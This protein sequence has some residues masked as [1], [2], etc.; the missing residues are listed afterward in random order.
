MTQRQRLKRSFLYFEYILLRLIFSIVRSLPLS[1]NYG[2]ARVFG[3]FFY[4]IDAKHRR[5]ARRNLQLAFG[6]TKAEKEYR[7][8]LKA[9]FQHFFTIVVESIFLPKY[10]TSDRWRERVEFSQAPQ[11]KEHLK[12]G[13]GLIILAPHLGNWEAA[14]F[15]V[16]L[17]GI[18]FQVI[19]R[20]LKNPYL[21]QYLRK[22]REMAG[23]EVLP[24]RGGFRG[25]VEA[26]SSGRAVAILHDQN[27]RKRPIFVNFF[28]K[29]AATDRSPA[30]LAL[31]FDTPVVVAAL[32]R[33]NKDF[34]F[35]MEAEFLYPPTSKE[36]NKDEIHRFTEQ[37]HRATEKMILN[38]PEQYFWLHDRYRTRP[39]DEDEERGSQSVQ[40]LDSGK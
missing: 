16:A 31:R 33:Q 4:R 1:W 3:S 19:A 7:K 30:F 10:L 6:S 9:S 23:A 35:R 17:A 24:R 26:I 13:R 40:S 32:L 29:K 27:Q 8:I 14:N 11:F 12:K 5:I 2:L 39:P 38:H 36:K 21:D 18:P 34:R 15:T 37:I 25:L 28:G 20:P 22:N